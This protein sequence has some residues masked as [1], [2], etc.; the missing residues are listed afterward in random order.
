MGLL[1]WVSLKQWQA[2]KRSLHKKPQSGEMFIAREPYFVF[3]RIEKNARHFAQFV[4]L[5]TKESFLDHKYFVP[6]ALFP[7]MR[8]IFVG[9]SFIP[10]CERLG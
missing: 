1:D 4:R 7:T 6:T 2:N 3:L 10:G 9:E 5:K 8:L